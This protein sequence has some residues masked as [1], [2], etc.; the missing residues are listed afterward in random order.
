MSSGEL[1]LTFFVACIVFGPSKLPMLA[2]HLG[3]LM[4]KINKLREQASSFWQNQLNEFQLL[5]NQQKAEKA[6]ET[7]EQVKSKSEQ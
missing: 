4:R 2:T 7:Y 5:E 3:M 1:L 6:D